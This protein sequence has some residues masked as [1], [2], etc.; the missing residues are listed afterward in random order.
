M[1][2]QSSRNQVLPQ[3][4]AVHLLK[5]LS[6]IVNI[7]KQIYEIFYH[8]I[9]LMDTRTLGEMKKVVEFSFRQTVH[10]HGQS[11]SSV[12]PFVRLLYF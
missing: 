11:S 7:L 10:N 3:I 8:T 5:H 9:L 1:E 4:V 6:G 2:N 12:K